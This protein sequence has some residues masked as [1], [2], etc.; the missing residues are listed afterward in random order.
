MNGDFFCHSWLEINPFNFFSSV[1]FV[2][3]VV[4]PQRFRFYFVFCVV[5][6]VSTFG[7]LSFYRRFVYRCFI[8]VVLFVI[9]LR[10]FICG[11]DLDKQNKFDQSK[12]SNYNLHYIEELELQI[13]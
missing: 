7:L 4:I 3:K 8:D 6:V 5:F 12:I 2:N 11:R 1:F 13:F 9:L 10:H